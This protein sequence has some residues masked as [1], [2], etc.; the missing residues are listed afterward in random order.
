MLQY[1]LCIVDLQLES[2]HY[3]VCRDVGKL[4]TW[5]T[6]TGT[7]RMHRVVLYKNSVGT[8][9][10]SFFCLSVDDAERLSHVGGIWE[11][12]D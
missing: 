3:R 7:Q 11:I 1:V 2:A 10:C 5:F 6:R 8:R 9:K 12:G 4:G